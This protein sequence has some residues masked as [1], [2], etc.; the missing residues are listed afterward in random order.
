M[1]ITFLA[2]PVSS[3]P[4]ASTCPLTPSTAPSVW[5][6]TGP[7]ACAISS[8]WRSASQA[9]SCSSPTLS[10]NWS[11]HRTKVLKKVTRECGPALSQEQLGANI[12]LDVSSDCYFL[13]EDD[14]FIVKAFRLFH[15]VPSFGFC[16]QER[17]RPG[18]LK[19]ELLK[20]LGVKPGP[21]YGRLKAG[22]PVT[23]ESGRLLLPSEVLEES[24]PGR[25]VC[26]LG[27]CSSALGEAPVRVCQGAD[28]LVHEAT[29]GD[30]HRDKAVEHGHS[31]PQMAAELARACRAKKLALY[32]FS[33]R[34][35]P[36][37]LQRHED[38]T[39]DVTELQRQAEQVLLD[40]GVDVILAEDFLT[41]SIP[42]HRPK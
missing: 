37:S 17:H 30:E 14:K 4:S 9:R 19:T 13:F 40:D 3:A 2:C 20:E 34:Y 22:Q 23:L 25:K 42:L 6:S 15:R 1:E 11:P 10:M 5:T 35:K 26:I 29:L 33:Q 38:D 21:V 31:T 27:D 28:L 41:I 18:R 39:D 12:C 8:G 16:V 36:S 24:I 7:A 32:H